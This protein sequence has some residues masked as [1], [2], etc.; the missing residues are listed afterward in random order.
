MIKLIIIILL[1]LSSCTTIKYY[2]SDLLQC[3]SELEGCGKTYVDVMVKADEVIMLYPMF[4]SRP[5]EVINREYCHVVTKFMEFNTR[6][7]CK[8]LVK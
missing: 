2:K 1:V 7:T 8:E 5:P 3:S 4:W 6:K